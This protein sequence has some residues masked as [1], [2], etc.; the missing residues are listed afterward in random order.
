MISF[1]IDDIF[2][3][4][5]IYI[6]LIKGAISQEQECSYTEYLHGL[7]SIR[8]NYRCADIMAQCNFECNITFIQQ[9]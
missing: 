5:N 7:I 4:I 1:I 9:F 2:I 6:L 3:K 8:P